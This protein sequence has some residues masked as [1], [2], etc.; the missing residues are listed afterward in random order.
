MADTRRCAQQ[1]IKSSSRL[2]RARACGV[3]CARRA[4]QTVQRSGGTPTSGGRSRGE[5]VRWLSCRRRNRLPRASRN[6]L[7]TIKPD[8]CVQHNEPV[9]IG[10]DCDDIRDEWAATGPTLIVQGS[11][12]QRWQAS[13]GEADDPLC[14]Q[15]I[16][17]HGRA[18]TPFEEAQ[19]DALRVVES[20]SAAETRQPQL[21]HGP[22][23]LI[24]DADTAQARQVVAAAWRIACEAFGSATER[25]MAE[26]S[27]TEEVSANLNKAD[28]FEVHHA[29]I[30]PSGSDVIDSEPD[31]AS[32]RQLTAGD[33]GAAG[34]VLS[35]EIQEQVRSLS[36]SGVDRL[37][38]QSN[39]KIAWAT[40][41]KVPNM[42]PAQS[43]D[44]AAMPA[45]Q[46]PHWRR[47]TGLKEQLVSGVVPRGHSRSSDQPGVHSCLRVVMPLSRF[48]THV[49][50]P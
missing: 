29:G 27:D 24:V 41:R 13:P 8:V 23:S 12:A 44:R 33:D 32:T 49:H 16:A 19:E 47:W 5:S 4:Y 28:D 39:T 18:V 11:T 1:E 50:I 46:R 10:G 6:G 35:P 26:H 37:L 7:D 17:C 43:G 38:P 20:E 9:V 2:C 40:D 21:E 15:V 42:W 3:Q 31:E 45:L 34:H 48:R 30:D 36:T 25:P 22:G 14:S